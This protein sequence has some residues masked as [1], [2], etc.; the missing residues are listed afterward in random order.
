M[1]FL[2]CQT[3]QTL[4]LDSWSSA[5]ALMTVGFGDVEICEMVKTG[6]IVMVFRIR[7]C[8]SLLRHSQ[9]WFLK[10]RCVVSVTSE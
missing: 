4:N 7:R 5:V 10:M 6:R 8:C 9:L 1:V 3:S 2:D